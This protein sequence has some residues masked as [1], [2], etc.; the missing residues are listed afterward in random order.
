VM[1]VP[2]KEF[3][4]DLPYGKIPDRTDFETLDYS[5][6]VAYW[7]TVLEKG[8]RLAYDFA[9]LVDSGAGIEDVQPF[10]GGR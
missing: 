5:S 2:S 6:R 9:A 4:A 1:V 7:S 8:K 10:T 3:V